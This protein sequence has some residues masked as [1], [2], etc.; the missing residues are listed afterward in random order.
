MPISLILQQPVVGVAWI[1]AILVA[2]SIHE[3]AHAATSYVLGD[4]T[5]QQAGRLTLRPF[6]H[7]DPMGF[8]M[9]LLVGFGWGK[10]VPFDPQQLHNRRWGPA[11]VALAGPASNLLGAI[12]SAFVLFVIDR[13][14]GLLAN[15][16]LVLFVAFSFQL[17][18]VL[19][20]FNLIPIPP[21]DGSKLLFS[22][23]DHSKYDG[24]RF[25]LQTRGPLILI[26]LIVVDSMLGGVIIGRALSATTQWFVGFF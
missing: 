6:A 8:F 17:H 22:I 24:A 12:A 16:L 5:A 3:C 13:F 14:T 21:L 11:L 18:I 1:A 25:F 7:V 26:G 4:H 2:L 23:M 15:N 9:L 20:L 10:P 19:M